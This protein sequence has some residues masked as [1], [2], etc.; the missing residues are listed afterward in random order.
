[1]EKREQIE[2]EVLSIVQ[3]WVESDNIAAYKNGSD[4]DLQF[5]LDSLELVELVVTLEGRFQIEIPAEYMNSANFSSLN[6]T[7]DTLQRFFSMNEPL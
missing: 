6:K 5:H 1:M 7:T 4:V 3:Q 2:A